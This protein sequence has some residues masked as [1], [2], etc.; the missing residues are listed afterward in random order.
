MSKQGMGNFAESE[1]AA[2]GIASRHWSRAHL[3]FTA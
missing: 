1:A 3:S 2:R